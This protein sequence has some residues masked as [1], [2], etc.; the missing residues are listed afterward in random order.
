L[1]IGLFNCCSCLIV[2]CLFNVDLYCF[3]LGE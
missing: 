2:N 1:F 3:T